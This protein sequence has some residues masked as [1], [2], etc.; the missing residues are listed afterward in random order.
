M[1]NCLIPYIPS[2][3]QPRLLPKDLN[4]LLRVRNSPKT[5]QFWNRCFQHNYIVTLFQSPT[6]GLFSAYID[7]YTMF[8]YPFLPCRVWVMENVVNP[9]HLSIDCS[10][11]QGHA[12]RHCPHSKLQ[13][14]KGNSISRTEL[15]SFRQ[16]VIQAIT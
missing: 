3:H 13:V 9:P 7:I 11:A 6:Y 8:S 1:H 4:F 2:T 15:R 14:M 12:H 10:E 5:L 16:G